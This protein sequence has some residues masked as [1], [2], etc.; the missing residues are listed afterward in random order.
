M[1]N[2]I[3]AKFNTKC[4]EILVKLTHEKTPGTV[5]NF[6]ALA[7]GQM[8][9]TAKPQGT[10]YYDGLTFHRVI[11]DFM[12]QGGCPRGSGSGGPGYAFADE[13]HAELTHKGPGILSMANAGPGTNG[14]QFFIT[15]VATP[16]LDNKHT[17]FG[18]VEQGQEVVNAMAQGDAIKRV[19]IVRVG[20]AAN[21]W[22][23][24]KAFRTFEMERERQAAA[25][26]AN[27]KSQVEELDTANTTPSG[28]RYTILEPGSG[29]KA[30]R[31]KTVSVHYEGRL[32]DGTVFDSSHKT[33]QP[34]V[35]TA[36]A[37]QVIPGWDEG[38]RLLHEGAKARFVI[39]P[40]LAYGVTGAGTLIPPNSTLI[41]DVEL[42]KVQ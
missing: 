12:I 8:E 1:E 27:G 10:P 36:G 21:G 7:E 15:H 2:G 14:S 32:I 25:A 5:G 19:E 35:F 18:Q 17:V 13:F 30:T 28:L 39:P 37:G 6:V 11:P 20:E 4:G 22:D 9:N 33:K 41:F 40:H 16:W 42:L 31:G 24:L 34:I 38:I 26:T 3:Y 23:A 29:Q